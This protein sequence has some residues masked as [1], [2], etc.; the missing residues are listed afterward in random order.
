MFWIARILAVGAFLAVLVYCVGLLIPSERVVTKTTIIDA[1][2]DRV[3][4]TMTGVERQPK[5]RS[6]VRQVDVE[7]RGP[8]WSW[9]ETHDDGAKAHIQEIVKDPLKRYELDFHNSAGYHGRW[10]AEL[11]PSNDESRTKMTLTETLMIDRP[12]MRLPA[13]LLINIGSEMDVFLGDLNR[14]SSSEIEEPKS[15]WSPVTPRPTPTAIPA[16][17]PPATPSA[18]PTATPSATPSASPSATAP[19]A[20]P[21]AT[22]SATPKSTAAATPI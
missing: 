22:P 1:S 3:F 9:T 6:K 2:P 19:A 20:A 13:Y 8:L 5:W 21:S 11:E 7:A 16:T 15:G 18:S 4:K 14:E 17:T 10:V 12:I